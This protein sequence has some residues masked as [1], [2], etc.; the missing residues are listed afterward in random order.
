MLIFSTGAARPSSLDDKR[1]YLLSYGEPRPP[2]LYL[3]SEKCYLHHFGD[4][5]YVH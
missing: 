3:R 2:G 1:V 4:Q 5:A